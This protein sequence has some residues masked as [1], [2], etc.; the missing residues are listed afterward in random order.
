MTGPVNVLC[1][2][3]PL[4]I[5]SVAN[6]REHW[7][8]RHRR[9]ALHRGTARAMMF[10]ACRMP[11]STGPVQIT[12][13]RIAPRT[14]DSDNLASGFKGTRDGVADWLGVDDGHGSLT[15]RYAQRK[16][17]TAQYAAEVVVEWAA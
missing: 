5:V 6:L 7:S 13:T 15:W 16:G 12:L 17:H 14:L 1:V 4:R 8:K 2:L 11:P 3:L 9:A 10:Q